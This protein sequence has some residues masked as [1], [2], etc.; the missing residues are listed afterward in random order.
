MNRGFFLFIPTGL[1]IDFGLAESAQK[2]K[3]RAEALAEHREKKQTK[4]TKRRQQQHKATLRANN[5]TMHARNQNSTATPA[6]GGATYAVP[7]STTDREQNSQKNPADERGAAIRSREREDHLKLLRK[8]ERAGTTG[9][10]A[11]EVLW[12]SQNQ[13]KYLILTEY[14]HDYSRCLVFRKSEIIQNKYMYINQSS[15]LDKV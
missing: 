15:D 1:L 12:H 9:F 4:S 3:D 7:P 5:D 14:I 11:P 8:V 13:V 10:R 6:C 2:W